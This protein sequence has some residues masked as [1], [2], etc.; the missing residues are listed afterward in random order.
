MFVIGRDHGQFVALL[1]SIRNVLN[2]IEDA[3]SRLGISGAPHTL[4]EGVKEPLVPRCQFDLQ[5]VA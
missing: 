5:P 3:P 4:A 2:D 1:D